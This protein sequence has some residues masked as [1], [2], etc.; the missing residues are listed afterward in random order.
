MSTIKCPVC[1]GRPARI[2]KCTACQEIRCGQEQC[3]G[4]RGGPKGW[5]G[6]GT[7]CRTCGDGRYMT[8]DFFSAELEGLVRDYQQRKAQA[9]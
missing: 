8:M 7:V 9:T 4:T 6:A 2:Y 5:A 1:G 3:T